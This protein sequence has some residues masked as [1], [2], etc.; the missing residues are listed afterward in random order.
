RARQWLSSRRPGYRQSNRI[1]IE[2][3]NVN[4]RAT[5]RRRDMRFMLRPSSVG[6]WAAVVAALA[7]CGHSAWEWP[8]LLG[9]A[10]SVVRPEFQVDPF[11]PKPLP[12]DWGVGHVTGVAVDS[13]DNVYLLHRARFQAG[14]EKTPE[15][16]VFDPA[17]NVI[18]SWG[19]SVRKSAT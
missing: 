11:W 18:R 8:G 13:K 4:E 1:R 7:V 16:I 15:L 10:P 17:G 3:G 12:N 5:N 2:L 9:A 14:A 6:V 19:A